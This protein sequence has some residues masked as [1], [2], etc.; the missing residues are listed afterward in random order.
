M[1]IILIV[2]EKEAREQGAGS[3]GDR[4]EKGF[5]PTGTRT[6]YKKLG[7]KRTR[8]RERGEKER[9]LSPCPLPPSPCLFFESIV[10]VRFAG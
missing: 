3:R 5:D 1:E 9:I 7:E 4:T 6:T 8:S 2:F 10:L